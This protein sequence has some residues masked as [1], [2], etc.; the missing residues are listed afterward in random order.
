MAEGDR[1]TEVIL[2]ARD[3]SVSYG[4]PPVLDGITVHVHK[5]ERACL[6]GRNGQGKSTLLKL[7]AGVLQPDRGVIDRQKGAKVAMLQQE[8]PQDL[9]GEVF[10]FVSD[11]LPW[12][13]HHRIERIIRELGLTE[14]AQMETLSGGMKRR[15]LL[16]RALAIEPDV[17]LLDEPTNHL[18]IEAIGF[19]E[20]VL[21]GF[22][23]TLVFVTHDRAFLHKLATCIVELDR[24]GASR[25]PGSYQK[26][27]N[28]KANADHAE[29]A[30]TR[31][32]D[33]K[34]AQEETWIRQGIKARRTRNEGRVRALKAMREERRRRRERQGNAHMRAQAAAKSGR[35]V[36]EAED[37]THRFDHN[38][39]L[40]GFSTTI[41]RGDRIGLIGPNGS[42]KT[43]L[44]R[45]LLGKLE[46]TSGTIREGTRVEVAYFDQMRDQ[47]DPDKSVVDNLAQGSDFV[48]IGDQRKHVIGYLQDFLFTPDRAR[49]PVS[50]LSGGE[51]NRLLLARLFT[52]P[53]NVLVMDE[54]TNDLDIETLE[55]LEELLEHYTGTVLLVSHDR[56]FLDSVVTSTLVFEGEGRVGDYVGGYSDWLRQRPEDAPEV[57]KKT[58]KPR[59]KPKRVKTKLSHKEA[60][61]LASLPGEIEALEVEQKALYDRMADPKFYAGAGQ[62]VTATQER[63]SDI[64]DELETAYA[65]WEELESLRESLEG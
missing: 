31:R 35:L 36:V 59:E 6:L 29:D 14:Q 23:G 32:F 56:Q 2:A 1:S 45:I 53:S 54:P 39:V 8:V 43:T 49:S 63:L 10:P 13:S 52:Q 55:R 34:L 48:D 15:A 50:T 41:M 24:G 40:E 65:R 19:L 60:E 64:E 12:E 62:Q 38:V 20:S 7:M 11:G 27:L 5:G 51:R 16:A 25:W 33:K 30:E 44:L 22:S 37:I 46:P 3:V 4:G 42:G 17:L 18:D 21:Q 61:Q 28:G 58:R 57:A 47:L 9:E 26:Y